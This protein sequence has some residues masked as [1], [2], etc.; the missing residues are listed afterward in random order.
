MNTGHSAWKCRYGIANGIDQKHRVTSDPESVKALYVR[1]LP[2][3]KCRTWP[4][5]APH[6]NRHYC[7]VNARKGIVSCNF[8]LFC[9]RHFRNR[10]RW[11]ILTDIRRDGRR[12][13]V[14]G[15]VR[16]K[17]SLEVSIMQAINHEDESET[18]CRCS[19]MF[20]ILRQRNRANILSHYAQ[21]LMASYIS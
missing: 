21:Q 2:L 15:R 12:F 3:P 1:N 19:G 5:S 10:S 7:L 17:R 18:R 11:Q 6:V 20:R 16:E 9:F 8:P 14:Y 4:V 13:A